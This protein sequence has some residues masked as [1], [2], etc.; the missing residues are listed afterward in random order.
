MV[1]CKVDRPIIRVIAPMKPKTP[2]NRNIVFDLVYSPPS[3]KHLDPPWVI[4]LFRA[5]P[6]TAGQHACG[7]S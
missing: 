1:A 2:K 5:K 7:Q 6:S 3:Q 4:N